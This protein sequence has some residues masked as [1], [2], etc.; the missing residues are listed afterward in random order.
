MKRQMPPLNHLRAFEAAVRHENFTKAAEELSVTQGAI[1]RHIHHLE[2]YLGF[3]LFQRVNNTLT[4]PFE[5]R[6]FAET[7]T[8][9]FDQINRG[10][11]T[12]QQSKRRTVLI[13]R[14]YTN[15]L[16]SWLIPRLPEFLSAN[17][18]FEIRLSAGRQEANFSDDDVDLAI[19]YGAGD[20][21]GLH[22]ELLFQKDLVAVCSPAFAKRVGLKKP[23]DVL[24]TTVYHTYSRRNEWAQWFK[25]VSDQP[26]NPAFETFAE[27]PAVVQQCLISGMGIALMQRQFV[28]D[29]VAAGQLVM[30]FKVSLR[31]TTGYYLVCP[32]EHLQ[33]PKN[34]AFRDWVVA[35][36]HAS[37]PKAR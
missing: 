15:F 25:Q 36:A 16:V 3:E 18:N 8:K 24:K 22:Q 1:S 6:Q 37:H 28:I 27:D 12:L 30:P 23:E 21:P 7:L 31:G 34:S 19:R 17:P 11:Q 26:F 9:A 10:S 2:E 20:W 4:V 29:A 32:A 14:S 35:L 5:S 33:L 13:L